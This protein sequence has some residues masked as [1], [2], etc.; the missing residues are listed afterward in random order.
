MPTLPINAI[1]LPFRRRAGVFS[2]GAGQSFNGIDQYAFVA[3]NGALDI[4]QAATDF[5][6]SGWAKANGDDNIEYLFGKNVAGS[7]V[8]RYGFYK[9]AEN[10]VNFLFETSTGLKQVTTGIDGDSD[11]NEHLVIGRID[12]GGAKAYVYVD[13]VLINPGGTAFTGTF[14]TMTNVYEFYLSE[15]NNS[16][17]SG[18]SG[19]FAN[20]LI[21]DVRIYNKNITSDANLAKLQNNEKIGDE[22]AWWDLP[23]LTGFDGT[24]YDLTGVNL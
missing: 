4:N 6:I 23:T 8:G 2:R 7:V 18:L 10:T 13:S 1:G 16:G 21:R 5:C 19:N 12:L 22:V 9:T 24:P 17:G 11:T 14:A 20:T 15:G 3:D